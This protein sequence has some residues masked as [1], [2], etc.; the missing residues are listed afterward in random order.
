VQD[1][2]REAGRDLPNRQGEKMKNIIVSAV[3]GAVLLG[4]STAALAVSG[5]K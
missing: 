4:M 5:E 3:A 1:A 2:R